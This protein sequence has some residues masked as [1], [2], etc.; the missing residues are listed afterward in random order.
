MPEIMLTPE[1]LR[2]KAAE[3]RKAQNDQAHIIGRIQR[4][5][6]EIW[7]GWEG[8]AQES[9]V[10]SFN[11]KKRTYKEFAFDMD[12]FAHFLAMYAIDME[13]IDSGFGH[14]APD[15]SYHGHRPHGRGSEPRHG[16]A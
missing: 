16:I 3:L 2:D 15:E 1:I 6:D 11:D 4:L 10:K 5:V 7:L 9:F 8:K 13:S 12:K 14:H